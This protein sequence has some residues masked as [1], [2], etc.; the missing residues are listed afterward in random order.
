M[1]GD[2]AI[3][4]NGS[5]LENFTDATLTRS[6]DDLTGRLSFSLFM[7]YMPDGVVAPS[8]ICG[9]AIDVY[10]AGKLAMT[11]KIDKRRG[12]GDRHGK[13]GT[14][15]TDEAGA[16]GNEGPSRSVNIGPDEYTV[17]VTARGKCKILIDSSHRHPTTNILRPTDQDA[18]NALVEG[19]DISVE[20]MGSPQKLDKVRFRDGGRISDEIHRL[21]NENSHFVYE[22]REGNLRV[23]DD[24]GRTVGDALVLGENI[25]TFSA[26]QSEDN[27]RAEVK[28]K[29]QR[30]PN[31][32]WGE[33]AVLETEKTVT[34]GSSTN[35][36]VVTL[37]HYGD[38]TP[39]AL[40]RRATFEANK[41][42]A[43]SKEITIEVFHV[44]SQGA[45]WDIGNIHYVEVPPEGIFDPMECTSLTYTVDADKTLK[46]T[47]TL[48]PIPA[49]G[50]SGGSA[51]LGFELDGLFDLIGIG[52]SRKAAK[53]TALQAGFAAMNWGG[54]ALSIV[55]P[56]LSIFA[57]GKSNGN[58]KF[59]G[60]DKEDNE[61]RPSILALGFREN[62][63]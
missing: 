13:S 25:L 38:A 20:F 41:R 21:C 8:A 49:G 58:D 36:A 33:D 61:K 46:T 24:T 56:L 39:E 27:Q 28:V 52:K 26:E 31:E 16:G 54:P 22:T 63:Q 35:K 40:E 9:A 51:G 53:G 60:L 1:A 4:I 47:L 5:E 19:T 30:S 2:F 34:D 44:Q 14:K 45:P 11:G 55:N 48:N 7:G 6:K 42:N 17:K 29:G 15:D 10:I 50:V 23:T 3:F 32:S 37:Q 12:T 59:K 57:T 43:A 18:I 62:G